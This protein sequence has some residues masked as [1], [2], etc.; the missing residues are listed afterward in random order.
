VDDEKYSDYRKKIV[1]MDEE[2]SG[3]NY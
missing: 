2:E 3:G 1:L